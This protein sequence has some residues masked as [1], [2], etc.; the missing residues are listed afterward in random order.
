M[1]VATDPHAEAT[2]TSLPACHRSLSRHWRWGSGQ[3]ER[4]QLFAA[5]QSGMLWGGNSVFL[6]SSPKHCHLQRNMSP[7]ESFLP[8]A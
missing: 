2:Q 4:I 1:V 5:Q 7:S 3:R 8:K 6:V